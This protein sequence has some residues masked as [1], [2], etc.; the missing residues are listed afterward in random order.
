MIDEDRYLVETPEIVSVAYQVAGLGS[1]CLAAVVD[2]L[3]ILIL[4]VI[5]GAALAWIASAAGAI[6]ASGDLVL[7]LW[8][9]ASFAALWGYYL[10]FELIW[11]GQS[12]GKRWLGLRVVRE[13]GRPITFTA[14]AIRNL[15][16]PIDFLPILYGIGSV[17]IFADRRGRRLGDLAAGSLVVR[18]AAPLTLDSLTA[19]VAPVDVAPRLSDAPPAPLLPNLDRLSRA[20]YDLVQD[21]LRRRAAMDTRFR[22]QLAEQLAAKLRMRLELP[23]NDSGHEQFLEHVVREYRVFTNP[24]AQVQAAGETMHLD[25]E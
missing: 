9:I 4:Q 17:A 8:A 11:N 20:E 6:D 12:P 24:P 18:E 19:T 5:L 21:F 10:L 16:R 22:P 15:I 7:A 14:S 13:G 25:V 23:V 1:R 2:T 3:L